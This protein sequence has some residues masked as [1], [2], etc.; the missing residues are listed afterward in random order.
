MTH[1]GQSAQPYSLAPGARRYDANNQLVAE[2]P[3][4]EKP[5]YDADRAGFVQLTLTV[6]PCLNLFQA[7]NQN[8]NRPNTSRRIN[9]PSFH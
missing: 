5:H 2:A 4:Q 9:R 6:R 8:R 3:L 1:T 7:L